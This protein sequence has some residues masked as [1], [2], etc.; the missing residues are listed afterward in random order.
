VAISLYGEHR[1]TYKCKPV[2]N[3]FMALNV[4]HKTRNLAVSTLY[5][6]SSTE[7]YE[8]IVGRICSF[9]GKTRN[10]DRLIIWIK[11]TLR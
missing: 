10:A 2:F 8:G 9:G 7:I 6:V 1:K 5:V 4:L 11:L 3:G